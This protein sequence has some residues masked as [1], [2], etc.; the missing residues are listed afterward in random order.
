MVI[1]RFGCWACRYLFP[2]NAVM[3]HSPFVGGL[4]VC[5][6]WMLFRFILLELHFCWN[7]VVVGSIVGS[8]N[9]GASSQEITFGVLFSRNPV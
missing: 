9:S 4:W 5:K 7:C 1:F 6:N 2:L 3:S 8:S